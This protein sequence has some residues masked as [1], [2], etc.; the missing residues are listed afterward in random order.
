M[1]TFW[2]NKK[3]FITGHT[4]FKGSWLALWLQ[5][6][7]ADVAGYALAPPT[8][9]NIFSLANV[10]DQMSSTIADIRDCV[11]LQAAVAAHQPEFVFHLAAQPLVRYSYKY[12]IETY[13]TNVMGTVNLLEAVRSIDSVRVVVNVTTDKCYENVGYL[14]GYNEDDRLGG[15]DP[16]SNS[17]ACAELVTQAFRLSYY[18]EAGVGLA[19][20]RAGNV[21]GGG[22]WAVDRLVPDIIQA[23]I[24]RQPVLIRNPASLRPW[25]HVLEP[26]SGYLL[27]AERMAQ[28]PVNYSAGWNFGPLDADI[29]P[30]SWLADY[31][32][33]HWGKNTQWQ[34]DGKQQPHEAKCLKLDCSKAKTKLNW[35]PRWDLSR[36]LRETVAWYQACQANENMQT[37]TLAQITKFLTTPIAQTTAGELME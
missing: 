30:V 16:Y 29:K 27:L 21:F 12:P 9:T 22:D 23:C 33:D 7:G 35:Q 37:I 24:Q 13:A 1:T 26:L 15:H 25:Q 11:S 3:V 18:T 20:A 32:I 28:D 36:G 6:L 8:D 17:K 14:H 34:L 5:S 2:R 31:I 10:A 4:G 19:T